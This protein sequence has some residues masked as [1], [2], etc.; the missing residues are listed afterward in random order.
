MTETLTA[1]PPLSVLLAH[2]LKALKLPTTSESRSSVPQNEPTYPRI[3]F[4]CANRSCL[5]ALG[6]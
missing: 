1:T 3:C 2:H 4:A 5:I 6:G